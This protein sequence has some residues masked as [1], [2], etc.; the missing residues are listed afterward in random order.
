MITAEKVPPNTIING[1]IKNNFSKAPPSQKKAPN[2]D[3]IPKISPDKVEIFL[4]T[5]NSI[6][7][8]L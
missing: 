7:I 5:C 4:I 6:K 1:G 8:E 2:I 3:D